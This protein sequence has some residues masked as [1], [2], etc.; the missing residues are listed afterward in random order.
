MLNYL[1]YNLIDFL[2]LVKEGNYKEIED[3]DIK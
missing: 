1:N 2:K 3:E